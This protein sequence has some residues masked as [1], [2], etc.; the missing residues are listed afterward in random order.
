MCAGQVSQQ[1]HTTWTVKFVLNLVLSTLYYLTNILILIIKE[2][3]AT[4]KF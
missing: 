4:P 1:L 2:G 3:R